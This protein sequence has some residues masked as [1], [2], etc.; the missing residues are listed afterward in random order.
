MINKLE[1]P[2]DLGPGWAPLLDAWQSESTVSRLWARDASVWTDGEE[3][4]W[5]GW[6]DIIEPMQESVAEF[7]AFRDEVQEAGFE[8][9]LLLGMGGSSLC[10][11]TLSLVFGLDTL[12]VLDS[13]DPAQLLALEEKL[14]LSKTLII[15]ASKSGSTLEPDIMRRYFY[16]AVGEAVDGAAGESFVAITDPG[17]DLERT[18]REDGYRRIFHG[19]PEI[20]GRYSALSNFGMVPGAVAGLDV[21]KFLGSAKE[22]ADACRNPDPAEN[23]GVSLGLAMGLLALQGRDKL[24]IVASETLRPVGAW[25]EQLIAESTG[26]LGKAIIPIDLE[27]P[28]E[29]ADYGHDRVFVVLSL[30]DDSP[31]ESEIEALKAA[32]HP[33]IRV[34]L[35]DTYQLGAELF[36]WEMATAAAGAVLGIDP[37]NQPDVQASKSVTK[38]LTTEYEKSG[39][40]AAEYPFYEDDDVALYTDDMN[41]ALLLARANGNESLEELLEAHLESLQRGRYFG[42]LAYVEMNAANV[43]TMQRARHAVRDGLDVATCLGFGPRFLHSTGQ[44]YKGGPNTGV[45]LQ[46]TCDDARDADVPGKAYSFGIVKAAQARGDFAVLSERRRRALRVHLKGDVDQALSRL[47]QALTTA[48]TPPQR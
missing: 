44:A 36:R 26:K 48:A 34:T 17:S 20:G 37:F 5:L 12:H 6:L 2:S 29:P 16:K 45:F 4:H 43:E 46:V 30:G 25:I 28:G 11:E 31:Y 8:S 9:I 19:V 21:A 22:M 40:L 10:P 41:A 24:T 3:A 38:K 23:P 7:T 33:V 39:S 15:V 42:L 1:L 32:G 27:E 18:A 47:E 35:S 14:D 13:T